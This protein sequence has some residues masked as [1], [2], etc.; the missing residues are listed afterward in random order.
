M[1][2]NFWSQRPWIRD[3]IRIRIRIHNPDKKWNE[4][5]ASLVDLCLWEEVDVLGQ[6]G[7]HHRHVV[8]RLAEQLARLPLTARQGMK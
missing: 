5:T 4:M 7:E 2:S 8:V 3:W 1:F 6:A